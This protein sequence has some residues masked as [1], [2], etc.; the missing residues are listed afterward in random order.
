MSMLSGCLLKPATSLVGLLTTIAS[1][2][3]FDWASTSV[4]QSSK[5]YCLNALLDNAVFGSTNLAGCG[6]G[7]M[8]CLIAAHFAAS[9]HVMPFVV[10]SACCL[11]NGLVTFETHSEV[12]PVCMLSHWGIFTF[13]SVPLFHLGHVVGALNCIQSS[14]LFGILYWQSV[15]ML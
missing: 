11:V 13:S 12:R 10:F 14:L 2:M 1:S 15:S 7:C 4:S 3:D 9:I 6:G 5:A 8:T